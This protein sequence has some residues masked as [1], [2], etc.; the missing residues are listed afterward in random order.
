MTSVVNDSAVVSR[1]PARDLPVSGARVISDPCVIIV[2]AGPAGTRAAEALVAAG[3]RP[4]VIDEGPFSGGQIY[5]RQPTNFTRQHEALYGAD[6]GKARALHDT[7]DALRDRIDYRPQTLAW[8]VS[9]DRLHIV[10]N[11]IASVLRFDVLILAT[12][13]TDRLAPVAGW[14]MPG[15]FS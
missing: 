7:F 14:T 15:C 1:T 3:L 5:R 13:A 8:T 9:D 2:G 12:G 10:T 6:A 4:I 11:G